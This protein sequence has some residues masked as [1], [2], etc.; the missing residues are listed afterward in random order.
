[1]QD[2]ILVA[3]KACPWTTKMKYLINNSVGSKAKFGLIYHDTR[4][5]FSDINIATVAMYRT[6][7]NTFIQIIMSGKI[8]N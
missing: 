5:F 2:G 6:F 7:S 4:Y 3:T 1:M 8:H